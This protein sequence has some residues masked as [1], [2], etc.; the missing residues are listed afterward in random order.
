MNR[1]NH[2][3]NKRAVLKMPSTRATNIQKGSISKCYNFTIM[4][5]IITILGFLIIFHTSLPAQKSEYN[6]LKQMRWLTGHWKGMYNGAPFYESWIWVNDSL[7]VNLSIE[8]N[9]KDTIVKENGFNR[10]RQGKIIHGSTNAVWQLTELTDSKMVFANDTLK[11]ANRIIWSHSA[12]D[13]W[14][15][16]IH[17]PGG[18]V[19]NY[20]LERVPWLE[21]FVVNFINK[22]KKN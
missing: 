16:E 3:N 1:I 8:I 18:R 20:D 14:L 19:I 21:R 7:M 12:N 2:K 9:E 10:L 15:T 5:N 22:N 6:S 13:H 4:R 17:N 11:Y